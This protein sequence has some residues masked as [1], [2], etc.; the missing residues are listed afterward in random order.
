MKKLILSSVAAA[1]L[2]SSVFAL[3]AAAAPGDASPPAGQ[4]HAMADRGFMLDAHLA[5]MKA[6]LKLTP[7]Q[8]KNWA[9]FEAAVRDAQKARMEDKRA[10]REA[11]R[12]QERPSPI[13]HMNAMA[14]RMAK[15]SA[16][17]KA[18][19]GAAKPLFDGLDE[20]QKH[21]FGPLMMTLVERGPQHGH[22]MGGWDKGRGE[23]REH[24]DGE[25]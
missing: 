3:G 1:A 7:D 22:M 25:N 5:G 17:I 8:E 15:V 2:A 18:I 12:G 6:A 21:H 24:G 16:S 9:P 11:M 20:A 10:M 4:M 14:D 23:H 13:D 19:A